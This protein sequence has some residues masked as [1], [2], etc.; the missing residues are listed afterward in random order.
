M[1]KNST[2][3]T[4]GGWQCAEGRARSLAAGEDPNRL[5]V[6]VPRGAG[7]RGVCAANALI[8]RSSGRATR[9][10]ERGLLCCGGGGGVQSVESWF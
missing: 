10:G 8:G 7:D 9:G 6:A 2:P 4:A 3:G 5:S 1:F